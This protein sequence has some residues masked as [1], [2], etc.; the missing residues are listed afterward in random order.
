VTRRLRI[1]PEAE[2]ELAAAARWYEAKRAGLGAE[3]LAAIDEALEHTQARPESF[4]I[5]R[6]GYPFRRHIL[7]RFPFVIF[8][9]VSNDKL[10]VRAFAHAARRPGYWQGR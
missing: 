5:W 9:T 8:F 4:P 3:F 2:A 7:E 10:E 1:A 6:Q